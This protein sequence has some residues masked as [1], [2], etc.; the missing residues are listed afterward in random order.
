MNKKEIKKSRARIA[1]INTR[2]GE[3]ADMLETQKRSL[4]TDEIS[5]KDALIQE[6]EILQLRMERAIAGVQV[7]EQEMKRYS[8]VLLLLLCITDRCRKVAKVS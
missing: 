8:P 6:K 4:T 2:L 3:M 1:E 7:P 5:E